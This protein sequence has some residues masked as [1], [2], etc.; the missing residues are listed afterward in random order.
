MKASSTKKVIRYLRGH[1]QLCIDDSLISSNIWDGVLR[2]LKD[3]ETAEKVFNHQETDLI[4]ST[5]P[6]HQQQLYFLLRFTGLRI[7]EALGL[8]AEEIDNESRII[9]IADNPYRSVGDGIKTTNSPRSVPIAKGLESWLQGLPNQGLLFPW[10]LSKSSKLTTPRYLRSQLGIGPHT[11][12]HHV[13]TCLRDGGMNE[14]VVGDLLGHARSKAN[15]AS[16]YGT[17][18]LQILRE[19]VEKIY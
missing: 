8:Q 11:L 5:L 6:K 18:T 10:C 16:G 9:R 3:E 4:A 1:W 13:A 2:H 17:T 15:T 19:A 14:R 7:Q 12:R